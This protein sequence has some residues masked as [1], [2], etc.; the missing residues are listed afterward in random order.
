[1][2]P[3]FKTKLHEVQKWV[4]S[5]LSCLKHMNNCGFFL[6]TEKKGEEKSKQNTQLRCL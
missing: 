6:L 1:M 3:L 2:L 5:I 4:S